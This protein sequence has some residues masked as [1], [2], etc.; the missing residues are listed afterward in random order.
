MCWALSLGAGDVTVNEMDTVPALL[1]EQIMKP[2][3]RSN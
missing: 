2:N 3:K 1:E